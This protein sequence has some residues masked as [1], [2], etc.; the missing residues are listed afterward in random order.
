MWY[1]DLEK[2]APL[3]FDTDT[4]AGPVETLDPA[5]SPDSRWLAYTKQLR[6]H[7]HAV[8]AYS[9]EQGKSIPD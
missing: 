9:L 2:G 5:W 6:N 3:C 8:F 4:Y 7:L 1:V